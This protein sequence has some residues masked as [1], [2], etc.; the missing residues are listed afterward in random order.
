MKKKN[1]SYPAVLAIVFAC[2]IFGAPPVQASL[3]GRVDSISN[4]AEAL[5]SS[6]LAIKS[7][8]NYTVHEITSN[9][10]TVREYVSPDGVIFGVAWNG[11][12][13]PDIRQLLGGYSGEYVKAV[14]SMPRIKGRHPLRVATD[15]VVVERWGHMRDWHGRAYAPSL[16]PAGVSKNVIR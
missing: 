5:K 3:G 15:N 1:F 12:V 8:K 13:N 14:R 6:G 16:L 10:V 7:Q 4:D 2:A 11:T 9:A